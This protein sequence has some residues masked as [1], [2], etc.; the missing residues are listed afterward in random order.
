KDRRDPKDWKGMTFGIPF[1]FSMHNYLLRY[2]LAE[3]GL[4]PDRDVQLR[5]VAPPEMVANLR[6]GNFDGFLGPDPINQR[7]VYDGVGFLH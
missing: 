5:V 7:A 4:D 2:Y 3:H 1:D 6:S